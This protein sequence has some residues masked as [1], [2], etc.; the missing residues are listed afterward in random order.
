MSKHPKDPIGIYMKE[1]NVTFEEVLNSGDYE[2]I[3]SKLKDGIKEYDILSFLYYEKNYQSIEKL[4]LCPFYDFYWETSERPRKYLLKSLANKDLLLFKI[5]LNTGKLR[6]SF[7]ENV[8]KT[9]KINLISY[10]ILYNLFGNQIMDIFE[11]I[12]NYPTNELDEYFQN[13]DILLNVMSFGCIEVLKILLND[14]RLIIRNNRALRRHMNLLSFDK[15]KL[16]ISDRRI[17]PFSIEMINAKKRKDK[18]NYVMLTRPDFEWEDRDFES[19]LDKLPDLKIEFSLQLLI[20]IKTHK[21]IYYEDVIKLKSWIGYKKIIDIIKIYLIGKYEDQ[22]EIKVLR[23]FKITDE[24]PE[25]INHKLCKLV[26][27]TNQKLQLTNDMILSQRFFYERK[28]FE[29]V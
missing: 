11:Y 4:L 22:N 20:L 1:N 25:E 23:F 17:K 28:R 18:L 24:L 10:I 12:F 9:K 15:F 27:Q 2:L 5:L 29:Y 21:L 14:K 16:L 7:D 26:Y 19:T 13:N 6:F 8:Y 3:N